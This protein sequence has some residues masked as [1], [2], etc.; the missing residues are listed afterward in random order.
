MSQPSKSTSPWRAVP[1]S[2]G[3]WRIVRSLPNKKCEELLTAQK[4][5]ALFKSKDG[6]NKRALELNAAKAKPASKPKTLPKPAKPAAP[7]APPAR[8]SNNDQGVREKVW[9]FIEAKGGAAALR[10]GKLTRK[11]VLAAC[12]KLGVGAGSCST[13]LGLYRIA[14]GVKGWASCQE[15]PSKPKTVPSLSPMPQSVPAGTGGPLMATGQ[16]FAPSLPPQ[17]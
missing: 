15:K 14:K 10:S 1:H 16:S 11:Q 7:P 13:Y 2:S 4:R 8:R 17:G 6:A 5:A 3:Q 9:G 12:V